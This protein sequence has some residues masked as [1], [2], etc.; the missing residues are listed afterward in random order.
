M[1]D[2]VPIPSP[3]AVPPYPALGSSNFNA[4]AYTYGSSMPAVVAGIQAMTQAG[5][6]NAIAANE[7][8]TVAAGAATAAAQ[9]AD[10]AL[11]YRN[12]ASSAASTATTRRD[13]AAA[14]AAAAD[15]SRIEAS[16]LNLGNKAVPPTTDNQGQALRAGAT[17]YDTSLAKWRVWDGSAWTE[18]ISA[19][20]GVSS[21]NGE[22][23]ALVKNSLAAYGIQNFKLE[24]SGAA[25]LNTLT[26]AGMYR[27]A[28]AAPN[29]PPGVTNSVVE[30]SRG[31]DTGSQTVIDYASG[32]GFTRGFLDQGGGTVVWSAWRRHSLRNEPQIA[33]SGNVV[34]LSKGS[35][36]ID[37]VSANKSYSF[38]N[39]LAGSS[40]FL[41]LTHTAGAISFGATVFSGGATPSF[42]TNSRHLLFFQ[43]PSYANAWLGY[44]YGNYPL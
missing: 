25:D 42:P 34:D 39:Q 12:Q 38:T 5:Y 44:Y 28:T 30:V 20:A 13:E 1:T 37:A 35:Y 40:F 18:G 9:Q 36:F 6:A 7:R 31:G 17:Y 32:V 23:G 29:M 10:A 41:E 19:V 16:K 3:P 15:A 26:T 24:T 14:S 21:L 11:G 22:T 43:L 4:E 8:A 2:V 33:V 27:F